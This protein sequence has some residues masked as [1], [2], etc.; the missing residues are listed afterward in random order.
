LRAEISLS[1]APALMALVARLRRLF[2]LDAQ[3]DLIAAQLGADPD[4]AARVGVRPG[5]RVPGAFDG[6]ETAAR[7]VLG[8]QVS[9]GA[10]TTLA[11]R[12][13]AEFGEPIDTP[14]REL[15]RVWPVADRLARAPAEAIAG[16][17]ILPSR[18]R[19]LR[20]LAAAAAR[21]EL[22]LSPI[23]DV[24]PALQRLEQLPGI[25]PWTAQYVAMRA[26]GWPDAFPESDLGI[27]KALGG[28]SIAEVRRRSERWQPWRAY[29][30][31]HLWVST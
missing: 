13:A 21:G 9:V 5:L 22:T 27:R 19:T 4:L 18:A 12:L 26:L 17:G 28:V 14:H 1:L 29:A 20:M 24:R 3:P 31:M 7:A 16:L 11:G 15:N 2:D 10:A 23:A 25:G 8:Q 6:F 30:A